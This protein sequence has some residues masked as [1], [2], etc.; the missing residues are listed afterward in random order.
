MAKLV[1]SQILDD[2]TTSVTHLVTNSVTK[3]KYEVR[4]YLLPFITICSDH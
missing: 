3:K 1:G 4:L 2:L